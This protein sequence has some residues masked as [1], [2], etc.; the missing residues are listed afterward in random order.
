MAFYAK[1]TELECVDQNEPYGDEM[2]LKWK[3]SG[4]TIWGRMDDNEGKQ[5]TKWDLQKD[6]GG[7]KKPIPL[8]PVGDG[9]TIELWEYDPDSSDDFCGFENIEP[10]VI[11]GKKAELRGDDARYYLTYDVIDV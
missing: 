5:G 1:F 10:K 2:Y 9:D 7:N 4:R 11:K 3:S 8:M 6:L